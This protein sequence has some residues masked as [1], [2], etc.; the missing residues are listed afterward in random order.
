MQLRQQLSL[1]VAD[2]NLPHPLFLNDF[3]IICIP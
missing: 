3:G 1:Q 2:F